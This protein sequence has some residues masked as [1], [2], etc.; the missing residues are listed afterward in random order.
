[1]AGESR[2]GP[3]GAAFWWRLTDNL[4]R[5]IGWYLLPI[6]ALTAIGVMQAGNTLQLFRSTGTLSAASNPLV[7][8]QP[9]SGNSSNFF[10]TPAGATSRIIGE[11]LR[12]DTFVTAVARDAGLGDALDNG[13]LSLDIIRSSVWAAT[14]GDSILSVNAEWE[15]PQT[16]YELVNATIENY[17]MFVKDTASSNS[18]EA[19][20]FYTE[21]LTE[22]AVERD[23]AQEALTTYLEK[24]PP[25]EDGEQYSAII[26][27]DSRRLSDALSATEAKIDS[28]QEKIDE[29]K[30]L[31]A[32]QTSLAG[33]RFTVIDQP[34]VPTAPES[35][36]VQRIT[37]VASFFMLGL[38]V[39]LAAL[40]L[41]TT[42]DQ[43]VASAADLLSLDGVA[44]VATTPSIR[45][46][47]VNPAPGKRSRRRR[48]PRRSR[49]AG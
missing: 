45:F 28:A 13:L 4:F 22:L 27:L 29:A 40:L 48:P 18:S 44:L 1:M 20:T 9:D 37:L 32:Q 17:Q 46:A 26:E 35:A 7:P 41:T 5:R 2:H 42:L 16:S 12:T 31:Q 3:G 25:L 8:E 14:K 23:A 43:T 15:D 47:G 11:R 49:G 30:L 39:A 21:Q 38:I 34:Q 6:L 36:L 19:I 24:L 10:E 33:R